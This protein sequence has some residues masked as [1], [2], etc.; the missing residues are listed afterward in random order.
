MYIFK[1]VIEPPDSDAGYK[2]VGA[3]NQTN[4][5]GEIPFFC[6]TPKVSSYFC[7]N[8]PGSSCPKG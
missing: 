4:I 3:L 7:P 1:D 8:I 5:K 6:P 2:V